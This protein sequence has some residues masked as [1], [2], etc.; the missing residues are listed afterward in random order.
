MC[1]CVL[2]G[3]GGRGEESVGSETFLLSGPA[4]SAD[5]EI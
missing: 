1:V 4:G 2:G 3:G 5:A